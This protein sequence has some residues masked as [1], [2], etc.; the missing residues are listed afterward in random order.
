MGMPGVYT[1]AN[2]ASY[3]TTLQ[4]FNNANAVN[5]KKSLSTIIFT[6]AEAFRFKSVATAFCKIL[7]TQSSMN[8]SL[9]ENDVKNWASLSMQAL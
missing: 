2:I 5:L 6:T 3:I 8:S 9:Y 7:G 4:N 1:H